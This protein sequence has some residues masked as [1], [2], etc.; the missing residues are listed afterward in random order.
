MDCDAR[1]RTAPTP[2]PATFGRAHL[3]RPVRWLGDHC[4]RTGW[5]P[6]WSPD[7]KRIAY[8]SFR[9]SDAEIFVTN[10]DGSG[11]TQIT[12]NTEPDQTPQWSPRGDRIAFVRGRVG[13]GGQLF[14]MNSDETGVTALTSAAISAHPAVWSPDGRR[15][16][17]SFYTQSFDDVGGI[18]V[19]NADGGGP[20]TLAS[21]I[22]GARSPA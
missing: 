3:R 22:K 2:T 1:A 12:W 11:E 20:I 21:R 8:H 14:V 15:L 6:S 7:G 5:S 16:V 10:A 17:F 18:A 19:V 13:G 9:D 4:A